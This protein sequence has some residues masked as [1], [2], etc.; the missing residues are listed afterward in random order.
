MHALLAFLLLAPTATAAS[1]VDQ[2]TFRTTV[3]L[4]DD[5]FLDQDRVQPGPLLAA[6]AQGAAREVPWLFVDTQGDEVQ[7]RHG[8]GRPLGSLRATTL[9]ELPTHLLALQGLIEGGGDVGEVDV[10]LA[11]LRGLTDGLDRFSRI[12]DGESLA[13]FDIRLKGTLVGIGVRFTWADEAL[14]VTS[15]TPSG[16]AHRAGVEAGDALLRVD[17]RSVVNMPLSEVLRLTQGP[18]GSRTVLTLRRGSN[19]LELPIERAEVVVPNVT[20]RDL[21]DGIGYVH[22]EHVSQRTVDNFRAA[23]DTLR[24]DGSLTRGL[25]LDLRGNTGGS[26]KEAARSAD[27]FLREGLLLRTV[28]HDG[29]R[30]QNLQAEM[31]AVDDGDELDVPVIILTDDRTASGSEILAGALLEHERTALVGT[32]TYGKGTVQ[33]IYTLDADTRLKLTVA[34]YLLAHDRRI[35]TSG[36]VPD[37]LVGEVHLDAYGVRLAHMDGSVPRDDL[38]MAVREGSGWRNAPSTTDVPLEIA[39]RALRVAAGPDR[40]ALLRALTGV[41]ERVRDDE[42]ER[43][44]QAY[45]VHGIDWSPDG[46]APDATWPDTEVALEAVEEPGDIVRVTARVTHHGDAPLH[47]ALVELRCPTLSSYDEVALPVGRLA[48]G[49]TITVDTRIPLRPGVGPRE[50]RVDALLHAQGRAT[51]QA[52]SAIVRSET[53]RVPQ[54]TV[55]AR[56]VPHG[57]AKGPHGHPVHRAELSVRHDGAGPLT[58]IE[59]FFDAPADPSVELLDR[60]ARRPTVAAGSTE[61]FDLTLERAPEAPERM[62][63]TLRIDAERYGRLVEW[64]IALPV[65]GRPVTW[66]P[67]RIQGDLPIAA[68]VGPLPVPLTVRDDRGI[69]HVRVHVDGRKVAWFEGGADKL[70]LAPPV[71]LAVGTHHVTVVAVD[72]QGLVAER[73]FTV[74]G[75]DPATADATD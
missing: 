49:Q 31:T 44:T 38:V 47:R 73:T 12:L 60:G 29:Q 11:L 42:L 22:I 72:D 32:R 61:R 13:S 67:P 9:V 23:T 41:A 33:K 57:E 45:A 46:N 7:L 5:L 28:G 4:V 50:D 59:V 40:P 19:E 6:A 64:D 2:E 63:L 48:P 70:D 20:Q 75:V 53:H 3:R 56:L 34:R 51:V 37:V 71:P 39:R 30:V 18:A 24:A 16:P 25:V 35:E 10:H 54:V 26:M 36:I 27:R 14:L 1:P 58:G 74:R 55:E 65:D 69:D 52:G 17:G 21:G 15:V 62:P 68:E 66:S 43:L 8:S